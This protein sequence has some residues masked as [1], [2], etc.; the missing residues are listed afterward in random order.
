MHHIIAKLDLLK[1]KNREDDVM[2]RTIQNSTSDLSHFSSTSL[3]ILPQSNS[4]TGDQTY[5]LFQTEENNPIAPPP[6][7]QLNSNNQPPGINLPSFQLNN[8]SLT[9]SQ[10]SLY[11]SIKEGKREQVEKLI[12]DGI[13]FQLLNY[14]QGFFYSCPLYWASRCGQTTI[15]KLLAQALVKENNN[16]NFL[17]KLFDNNHFEILNAIMDARIDKEKEIDLFQWATNQ[18]NKSFLDFLGK[19][20]INSEGGIRIFTY[21]LDNNELNMSNHIL[22]YSLKYEEGISLLRWAVQNNYQSLV[23]DLVRNRKAS[24]IRPDKK[25]QTALHYASLAGNAVITRFLLL[26]GASPHIE[27]HEKRTP[28]G[29]AHSLRHTEVTKEILDYIHSRASWQN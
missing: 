13:N 9:N 22:N 27:N 6:S 2:T 16:F 17:K 4:T 19:N 18:N 14:E 21:C 26:E 10:N 23:L 3:R 29:I 20:I 5:S 11:L 15:L 1:E 8:T 28:Y 25:G 7:P 24:V 12:E